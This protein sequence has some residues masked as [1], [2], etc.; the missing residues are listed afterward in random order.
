MAPFLYGK[1]YYSFLVY[2]CVFLIFFFKLTVT[3]LANISLSSCSDT[4]CPR[5]ATNNVEHGALAA[6][7]GLGGWVP[8]VEPTGLANAGLGKKWLAGKPADTCIDAGCIADG[9][10]ICICCYNKKEKNK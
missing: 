4:N 1:F 3:H 6:S 2:V 9:C 5:L 7:G 10:G 8:P